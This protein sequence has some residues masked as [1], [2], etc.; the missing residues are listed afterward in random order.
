MHSVPGFTAEASLPKTEGMRFYISKKI[1]YHSTFV[2][3]QVDD[4]DVI[5][6]TTCA[7]CKWEMIGGSPQCRRKCTKICPGGPTT[8]YTYTCNRYDPDQCPT[9]CPYPFCNAPGWLGCLCT[10]NPTTGI[11]DFLTCPNW[12][13]TRASIELGSRL[14]V[15]YVG[16]IPLLISV[17]IIWR[18]HNFAGIIE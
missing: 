8:T 7:K 5:C 12:S 14:Y 3:A 10:I 13:I 15:L 18:Y 16:Q 11:C 1:E 17:I 6:T 9:Q 2:L 4:T